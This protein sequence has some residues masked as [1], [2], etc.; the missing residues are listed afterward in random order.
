MKS[1]K[2]PGE[3]L[4][5]CTGAPSTVYRSL[6]TKT[7]YVL[8][9]FN[10]SLP[11]RDPRRHVLHVEDRIQFRICAVLWYIL[12]KQCWLGLK[13]ASNSAELT[14]HH[15]SIILENIVNHSEILPSCKR[16]S[17]KEIRDWVRKGERY[18]LLTLDLSGVGIL[19]LL[20]DKTEYLCVSLRA[21]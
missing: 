14:V 7:C 2:L 19:F 3:F 4:K 16:V 11:L 10:D 17:A 21:S 6:L 18:H 9:T 12:F 1:W 13:Y 5:Q 15:T 20:P 8:R